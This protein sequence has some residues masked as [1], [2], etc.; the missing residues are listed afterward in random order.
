MALL[1][2]GMRGDHGRYLRIEKALGQREVRPIPRPRMP[3][4][5]P[6]AREAPVEPRW[7]RST[8]KARAAWASLLL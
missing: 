6:F 7:A 5:D 8:M 1:S 3:D 2:S 4:A